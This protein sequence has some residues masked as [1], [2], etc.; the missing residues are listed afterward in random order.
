MK[1]LKSILAFFLSLRTAVW[2]IIAQLVLLVIGAVQ[3]PTMDVYGSMNDL[4]LFKWLLRS[5]FAATW[6]MWGLIVFLAL[7]TANTILCSLESL[8]KKREGRRWLLVISPQ[9]M[10]IGFLFILLAHLVSAAGSQKWTAVWQEGQ[11]LTLP[12]AQILRVD[13]V[14]MAFNGRYPTDWSADVRFFD[15]SG[16]TL[17]TALL[18]PNKP[19][20]QAG[21]GVYL[22]EVEPGRPGRALIEVTNEPGAVWALVGGVLFTFGTIGLIAFKATRER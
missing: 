20:F 15:Q 16:L 8:I 12:N 5:P 11:A 1:S 13:K 2:L 19:A 14:D 22:K 17:R 21:L 18:A 6:W 10:H 9:V 4:S 3:M 7:L